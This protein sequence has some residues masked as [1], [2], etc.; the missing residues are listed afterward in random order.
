MNI[1]RI[2][3]AVSLALLAPVAAGQ[4]QKVSPDMSFFITSTGM[5]YCFAAK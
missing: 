5:F 3:V 2:A 1:T 4:A